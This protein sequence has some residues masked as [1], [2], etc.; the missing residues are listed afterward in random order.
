[1]LPTQIERVW[2]NDKII[3]DFAR[4]GIGLIKALSRHLSAC[5]EGLRKTMVHLSTNSIPVK[6]LTGNLPRKIIQYSV[7]DRPA[8]S[9]LVY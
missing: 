4:R 8:C 9:V 7:G 3:K 1:M 2:S 6:V 5:L